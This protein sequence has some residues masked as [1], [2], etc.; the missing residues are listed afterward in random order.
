M[1]AA[2]AILDTT[3]PAP[4]IVE[5]RE[6]PHSSIVSVVAWSPDEAEYGLQGRLLRGDGSLIRDHRLYV[7][8]YFMGSVP[9]ADKRVYVRPVSLGRPGQVNDVVQTVTPA[10]HVLV[11]TGVS[12]DDRACD[13]DKHT[14]T[15][16]ETFDIRVPDALLRENRDSVAVRLYRRGGAEMVVTIRR[17]LIDPYL[18]KLDS[19]SA[20]LRKK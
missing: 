16:F 1:S 19:V 8:T 3:P 17:E 20:A 18:A 5:V 9:I 2:P 13:Y 6:F 15:P 4:P 11:A 12:H 7:S 14:C 10:N